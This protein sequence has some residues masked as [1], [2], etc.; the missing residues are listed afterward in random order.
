LKLSGPKIEVQ[1]PKSKNVLLKKWWLKSEH[2]RNSH[3]NLGTIWNRGNLTKIVSLLL[4]KGK[5]REIAAGISSIVF[6]Y[7]R[8]AASNLQINCQ[9]KPLKFRLS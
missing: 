5:I 4:K 6:E 1:S 2:T 3:E 7:R 9:S 8:F